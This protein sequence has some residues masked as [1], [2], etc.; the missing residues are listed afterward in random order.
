LDWLWVGGAVI[1]IV[2]AKGSKRV[3]TGTA[4]PEEIPVYRSEVVRALIKQALKENLSPRERTELQQAR[5][6]IEGDDSSYDDISQVLQLPTLMELLYGGTFPKEYLWSHIYEVIQV[7]L[8]E[9]LLSTE[10]REA[11]EETLD[12][13]E[14]PDRSPQE[15]LDLPAI[16]EGILRLTA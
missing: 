11:L 5:A 9:D 6:V 2:E 13:L 10:E 12:I 1:A 4:A 8:R 7:I 15:A 3:K 16:R 14:D